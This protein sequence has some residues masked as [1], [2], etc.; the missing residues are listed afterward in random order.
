[1]HP[2]NLRAGIVVVSDSHGILFTYIYFGGINATKLHG[3]VSLA[4]TLTLVIRVV[5]ESAQKGTLITS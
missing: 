1:M 5:V 3:L 2:L 4:K